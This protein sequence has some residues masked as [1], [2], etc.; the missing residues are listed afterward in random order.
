MVL[1]QDLENSHWKKS[2]KK[3][4][5]HLHFNKALEKTYVPIYTVLILLIKLSYTFKLFKN[6]FRNYT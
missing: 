6:G 4:C 2:E 1:R 5:T 3:T